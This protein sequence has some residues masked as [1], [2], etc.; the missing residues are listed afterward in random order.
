DGA[1]GSFDQ[2]I[3]ARRERLRRRLDDARIGHR[4]DQFV[5]RRR[6]GEVDRE[7]EIDDEP[8]PDLL[9]V[10]HDAM[11]GVDEK[12]LDEDG[13][14][15]D[16]S[17]SAAATLSACTV[18]ATS[19]TRRIAAPWRTEARCAAIDPPIRR[20]GGA[21]ETASMK[22]L[23]EAPTSSGSPNDASQPR[24]AIASMLCSAVLPKPMPGS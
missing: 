17:R 20:S 24:R 4:V 12:T 13:V 10:R 2:A 7:L 16:R 21:G 5:A 1:G 14:A 9:L 18:S 6:V 15:H 11:M 23:R 3:A 8:L 22:R 19:C